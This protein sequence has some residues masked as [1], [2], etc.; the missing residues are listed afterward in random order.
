[1]PSPQ[2]PPSESGISQR[3]E[4][5]W[6]VYYIIPERWQKIDQILDEALQ[7]EGSQR[8]TF[9]DEACSGDASLRQEV[10]SL[11]EAS[12]RA[13]SFI[14][15]PALEETAQAMAENQVQSMVGREIGSYKVLSLLGTGGMGEVYLAQ[16]AKLDRKVALKFLTEQFAQDDQARFQREAQLLASLNHPNIAAIYGL[17]EAN[18]LRFLV[19]ELV[20]GETLAE[21]LT[22]GPPPMDEALEICHQIAEGLEAAHES[23]V[24]HRDLK[25]ANVKVT[26]EG[27]VKILDFGLAKALKRELSSEELENSSTISAEMTRAGV[28]LGTAA[29]MSPEQ[30][31]GKPVDRRADIWAFGCVLYE[32]LTSR[33]VFSGETV[34]DIL[35]AIVHKQP[36]WEV[37][38]EKT[39]WRIRDLLRRC[40]QKDPHDRLRHIGDAGIEVREALREPFVS[41]PLPAKA[42]SPW[43]RALPWVLVGIM[44]VVALT[45][46]LIDSDKSPEGM[47]TVR[48]QLP[49][50]ERQLWVT[51]PSI[52]PDGKQIVFHGLDETGEGSLWVR[53]LDSLVARKLAACR[54][55]E[56]IPHRHH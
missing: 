3:S 24:I 5:T 38:P 21:R 30:T 2:T 52:S 40:L 55:F 7:K 37:L 17:E 42:G 36:D 47:G 41:I 39:P 22:G 18:G 12:E 13:K 14:E 11:L 4:G 35:G 34:T 56:V 33:Q 31:R 48:L 26:P 19:L 27:K 45:V 51:N 43:R 28:I 54:T 44:T 29:Y 1:M 8:E 16:D 49:L 53:K 23:G 46:V 25:P 9:L 32:A 6:K 15:A 10:E 20:E 50:P